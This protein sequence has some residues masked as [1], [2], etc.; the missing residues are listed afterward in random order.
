NLWGAA[1]PLFW[2]SVQQVGL[3][4]QLPLNEGVRR[5]AR[6]SSGTLVA[7]RQA[8][9]AARPEH[10]A[11]AADQRRRAVALRV[12]ERR[13]P[14]AAWVTRGA[15]VRVADWE[16]ADPAVAVLRPIAVELIRPD[17]S[18]GGTRPRGARAAVLRVRDV[19]A[20][21]HPHPLAAGDRPGTV[22]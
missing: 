1:D 3:P 21:R 11:G 22:R 14:G 6:C 5:N 17:A 9:A 19:A 12:T 8:Q 13:A 18:G 20:L 16:A 15:G 2:L 7:R 10:E 4:E